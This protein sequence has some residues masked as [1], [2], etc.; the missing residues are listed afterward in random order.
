MVRR[1]EFQEVIG[2]IFAIAI[3]FIFGS[4][5][6]SSL[7]F[8]FGLNSIITLIFIIGGVIIIGALIKKI[9]ELFN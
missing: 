2:V 8:D 6:L 5:I 9:M 1:S 4:V 3:F 7:K